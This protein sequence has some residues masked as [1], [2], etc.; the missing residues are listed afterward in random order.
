[1]PFFSS[2]KKK[3]LRENSL[4][5]LRL[6]IFFIQYIGATLSIGTAR[7]IQFAQIFFFLPLTVYQV[8]QY[9]KKKCEHKY[10][11]RRTERNVFINNCENSHSDTY[12]H[13]LFSFS[14]FHSV[15]QVCT[16]KLH[17]FHLVI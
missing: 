16:T 15:L 9:W 8:S 3:I 1:M 10:F 6:V 17:H 2:Y 14:H 5:D 12:S 7:R 13:A 4:T 11:C